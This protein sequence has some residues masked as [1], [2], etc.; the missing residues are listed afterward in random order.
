MGNKL[1]GPKISKK[2]KIYNNVFDLVDTDGDYTVSSNELKN[3]SKMLL[4]IHVKRE[5]ER[6][7]RLKSYDSNKYIYNVLDIK[8]GSNLNRKKFQKLACSVSPTVW[9]EVILP[10]LRQLEIKRLI[11]NK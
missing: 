2:K 7:N 1:C 10:E 5:E 9:E 8:E 4:E 6:L 11:Q 3:L